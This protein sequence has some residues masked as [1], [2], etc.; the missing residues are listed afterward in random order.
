MGR[1]I[2][3]Q[4]LRGIAVIF[5]IF[6]HLE[7]LNIGFVGV[8]IFFVLS[9]YFMANNLHKIKNTYDGFYNGYLYYIVRRIRRILPAL[10][11]TLLLSIGVSYFIASPKDL[12]D[13]SEEGIY[14]LIGLSNLFYTFNS[15]Y[16]EVMAWHILCMGFE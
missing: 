11:A 14:A 13:Y 2:D 6:Y 7:I 4:C 12:T 9:G 3:L 16:F 8:D 1:R 15:G 10:L 5:V